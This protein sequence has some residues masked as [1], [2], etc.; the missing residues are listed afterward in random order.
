MLKGTTPGKFTPLGD[1]L[2]LGFE[3]ELFHRRGFSVVQDLPAPEKWHPQLEGYVAAAIKEFSVDGAE[4]LSQP[5]TLEEHRKRLPVFLEYLRANGFRTKKRE[6]AGFHVHVERGA[7]GTDRD[8]ENNL[9]RLVALLIYGGGTWERYQRRVVGRWAKQWASPCREWASPC[10][11]PFPRWWGTPSP[12]ERLDL[13]ALWVK[14][15]SSR[16]SVRI[17][18]QHRATLEFRQ[19]A[20]SLDAGK[21][22]GF[23]GFCESVCRY[24]RCV[25][26]EPESP[27]QE[28]ARFLEFAQEAGYTLPSSRRKLQFRIS[29]N[30]HTVIVPS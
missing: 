4:F 2:H 17:N 7:L 3:L 13:A 23:L 29:G 25:P 18:L 6:R 21:L 20:A 15:N 5:A 30:L 12:E 14:W 22:L 9:E 19:G 1:G 8:F 11:E 10:R 16:K 26:L 28:L 27:R 24:A